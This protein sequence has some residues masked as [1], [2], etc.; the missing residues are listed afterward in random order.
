MYTLLVNQLHIQI[1]TVGLVFGITSLCTLC[2]VCW[3][4]HLIPS[5]PHAE[6]ASNRAYK[7]KWRFTNY[8]IG[9]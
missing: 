5:D 8:Q 1:A 2:H 3:S 6:N 4:R 9:L 7:P